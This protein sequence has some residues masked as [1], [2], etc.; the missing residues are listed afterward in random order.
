[1]AYGNNFA[2]ANYRSQQSNYRSGSNGSNYNGGGRYG[3]SAKKKSGA[4]IKDGKNGKPC[5]TA[6]KKT[7]AAFLT[8][9]ACPNNGANA[10]AKDGSVI[11]NRKGQEYARWTCTMVDRN[12]GSVSTHSGLYNLST[13]KL[14]L[15]ELRMVVSPQ[16]PN[17]G[18]WGNS[19]VSKKR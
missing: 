18:F 19:F 12:T 9:I 4:R 5:I 6:W 11:T 10:L 8:L 2:H 7:R 16:A 13:G 1:M 17:G 14:Y 3:T 15:P